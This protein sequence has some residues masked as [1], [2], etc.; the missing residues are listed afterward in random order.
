[1]RTGRPKKE[2]ILT[3]DEKAKLE[4]MARRPKTDQRTALRAHIVL[5]CAAGKNNTTVARQ[6]GITLATV[7]K[8]RARFVKQGLGGLGDAPRP[9]QPRKISDAMIEKVVART[10]EKRPKAAT[11]WSTRSMAKASGLTQNAIVRIW[12]AFGLQ[13][14][15]QDN[16]KLSTNAF[17]VKSRAK[18]DRRPDLF[19]S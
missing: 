12:R 7:G 13:P 17:F 3:A 10:L 9:G 16:F 1:M 19:K 5:D 6:R 11:H 14:H 2:L 15:L 4:M 8:W 18:R